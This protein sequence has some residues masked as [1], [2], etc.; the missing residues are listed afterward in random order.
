MVSTKHKKIYD[1]IFKD[2]IT[3]I[4]WPKIESMLVALGA[5]VEE[6]KG[7]GVSF[8]LNNVEQTFIGHQAMRPKDMSLKSCEEFLTAA[9]VKL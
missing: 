3:P 9:Q 5:E 1:K 4:D 8:L 7:S 2:P 6:T